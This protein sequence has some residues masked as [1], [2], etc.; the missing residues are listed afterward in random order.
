MSKVKK[1]IKLPLPF[2]KRWSTYLYAISLSLLIF[3]TYIIF[4][5]QISER[6][7]ITLSFIPILLGIIYEHR[8]LSTAWQIIALKILGA[9]ILSFFAFLPGKNESNYDFENHIENWP[10]YFLVIFVIIS[11]LIHDKK[12][13]TKLTEGITLIQSISIIYWIFDHNIFDNLNLFTLIILILS[14]LISI[15]SLVHAFTYTPLS[16]NHRLYL[17]IWSSIIMIVFAVENIFNVFSN[18]N[19]ENVDATNAMIITVQYFMLGV[20]SMYIVKTSL[21]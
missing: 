16:R 3:L 4:R 15:Y 1:T 2:Y 13:V 8:R 20:S 5:I 9:L 12:V 7:L 10:F 11:V 14:F 19:I 6:K 18:D 21:C 17:S